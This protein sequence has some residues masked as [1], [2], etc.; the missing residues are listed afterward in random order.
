MNTE[1]AVIDHYTRGDMAELVLAEARKTATDPQRL[2]VDELGAYDE[3]HIG[4]RRATEYFM[5]QLKPAKNMRV[6]DIGCGIGGA[7]RFAAHKYGAH[8]TGIDLTPEFIETACALNEAVGMKSNPAFETG[9]ALDL[10]FGGETFDMAYTIHAAM[11][12][13][14]KAEMY[15]AAARVLK[16]G[17][18]FGI[19]DIMTGDKGGT[20]EFPVPWS[21]HSETSFLASSDE[22][23]A[24]LKGAGFEITH[25]ESRRDFALETFKMRQGEKLPS[26]RKSDFALKVANLAKNV[27]AGRCAP[28]IIICRKM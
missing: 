6:L 22:V 23:I 2:S 4:G 27:E 5:A 7:A 14:D 17:A 13:K 20:L 26:F 8:V 10:S 12:I 25:S 19:Y 28:Y 1:K 15:R 11:N 9:S 24:M 16:S 21:T 3:F 18:I